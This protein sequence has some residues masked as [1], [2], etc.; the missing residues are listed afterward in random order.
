LAY[1]WDVD[2]I[3]RCFAPDMGLEALPFPRKENK[4]LKSKMKLIGLKGHE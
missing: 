2:S 3:K 4:G 1:K